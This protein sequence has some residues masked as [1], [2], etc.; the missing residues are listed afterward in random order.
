MDQKLEKLRISDGSWKA[1]EDDWRSQCSAFGEDFD[2]YAIGSLPVLIDA[3]GQ[4]NADLAV[5]SLKA[6]DGSYAAV[7]Q[8]N[9]A[10]LPGY[11]GKVLRVRHMLLSPNHDFG[12]LDLVD[13][14]KILSRMFS[15]TVNL[16]FNEMPA[17]HVKFHLRSPGDR[18]FF[19]SSLDVLKEFDL[20]TSVAMRGAWL[21]LTLN[22]ALKAS[23]KGDD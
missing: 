13:Y 22:T 21:Y 7:A 19:S 18:Q 11:D 4:E 3:A 15:R 16:A 23:A 10:L 9:T 6:E 12:E 2:Q 8:V 20:F 17:S 1:F 14:S 5:M